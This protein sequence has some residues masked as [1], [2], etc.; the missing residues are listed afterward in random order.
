[1]DSEQKIIKLKT[2]EGRTCGYGIYNLKKGASYYGEWM[3]DML[4]GIGYEIWSDNS[5]Y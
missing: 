5:R 4:F 1:M 3:D 2:E